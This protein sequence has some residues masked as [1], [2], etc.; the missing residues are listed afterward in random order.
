MKKVWAKVE[1]SSYIFLLIEITV[2]C[3]SLPDIYKLFF[4]MFCKKLCQKRHSRPWHSLVSTS[5]SVVPHF[6]TVF[7]FTKYFFPKADI[8]HCL[9]EILK[10][11]FDICAK[12]PNLLSENVLQD[13]DP[14]YLFSFHFSYINCIELHIKYIKNI[15]N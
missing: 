11:L 9:I 1:L 12:N 15:L 10:W 2:L 5:G 7:T 3:W 8:W 6:I 13:L 14:A 4:H